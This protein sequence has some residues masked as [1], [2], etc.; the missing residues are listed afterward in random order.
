[1]A[2]PTFQH[3]WSRPQRDL[4]W[5]P[6]ARAEGVY[7]VGGDELCFVSQ[8]GS[9]VWSLGGDWSQGAVEHAGVLVG[10]VQ[11]PRSQSRLIDRPTNLQAFDSHTG[12]PL[13][14]W[15]ID[16]ALAGSVDG[17]IL[18]RSSCWRGDVRRSSIATAS[19]EVPDRIVW[20]VDR[21][22]DLEQTFRWDVAFDSD[23]LYAAT[24]RS[25]S[26]LRLGSGE[27][28]WEAEVG[29]FGGTHALHW[30][31]QVQA[32]TLVLTSGGDHRTVALDAATGRIRWKV[33]QVFGPRAVNQDTVFV[34]WHET[35]VALDL[36]SGDIRYRRDLTKGLRK[37]VRTR[38][39]GF[40]T[41]LTYA[42]GQLF[43]GD[44]HGRLWVID[45]ENGDIVWSHLPES[46]TGY[47]GARPTV[48]GG[49]LYLAGASMDEAVIPSLHCY[50]IR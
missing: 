42:H 34:L 24:G 38:F 11:S 14:S 28:I 16:L 46:A 25:V 50:R 10:A 44:V 37:I 1:M 40:A 39:A 8:A 17:T 12:R 35:L 26:A 21:T 22:G 31:P 15:P 20:S 2:M 33:D 47:L 41:L 4:C 49:F 30:Q 29:A 19:V 43:A 7:A 13:G 27:L 9:A 5:A 48:A 6:I 45:A 32:G 18:L 23:A 3:A 36:G